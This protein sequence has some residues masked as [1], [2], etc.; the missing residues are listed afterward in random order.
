MQHGG[1]MSKTANRSKFI[2]GGSTPQSQTS[3]A[4]RGIDRRARVV[5]TKDRDTH[6]E[7]RFTL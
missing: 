4:K 3:A 1:H 6:Q 2:R 5:F 7:Q